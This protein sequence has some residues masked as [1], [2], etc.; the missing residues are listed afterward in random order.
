MMEVCK[1]AGVAIPEELT[2][3]A[4]NAQNVRSTVKQWMRDTLTRDSLSGLYSGSTVSNP[5]SRS[6]QNSI[7][8]RRTSFSVTKSNAKAVPDAFADILSFMKLFEEPLITAELSCLVD[9]IMH[10]EDLFCDRSYV[11]RLCE[12]GGFIFKLIWHINQSLYSKTIS[13]DDWEKSALSVI[14]LLKQIVHVSSIEVDRVI[15]EKR[16][17][18]A[19]KV[20]MNLLSRYFANESPRV[21]R[22]LPEI[23]SYLNKLGA[24]DLVVSLISY[25]GHLSSKIFDEC[26]ELGTCLLNDG[27]EDVQYAFLQ[28]W[29]SDP[30]RSKKF[31]KIIMEKFENAQDELK[32]HQPETSKFLEDVDLMKRNQHSDSPRHT[33]ATTHTGGNVSLPS[34]IK[35]QLDLTAR[36]TTNF[37]KR[38]T[39]PDG[40]EDNLL[41]SSNNSGYNGQDREKDKKS[42]PEKISNSLKTIQNILRFLQLL[43]ENHNK[44][45]Q[46]YLREQKNNKTNFDL[47]SETLK[48]LDSL[49]GSTTGGLGLLGLYVK[50]EKVPIIKQALETLTEYCQGPC[51]DNQTCIANHECN[52]LDIIIAL[53]LN[54]IDPLS[55]TRFDLVLD[56]K[57]CASKVWGLTGSFYF[58]YHWVNLSNR[59]YIFF[60]F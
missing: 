55:S 1:D 47:V 2:Q 10:A 8:T 45:L 14:H 44:D 51:Y 50:E 12:N 41:N 33:Y 18:E 11:Y 34:V 15:N 7:L 21:L 6:R 54:E 32:N 38:S 24:V 42:G 39:N 36:K 31:F 35:T 19:Y 40:T 28:K 60:S 16:E 26:I 5:F 30:S 59:F 13:K 58:F 9:I 56:L 23:Q 53:V 48:I 52:G 20:R 46:N 22:D 57:N 4:K 17:P 29:S 43:C 27:N 3:T 25:A 49:C 37:R